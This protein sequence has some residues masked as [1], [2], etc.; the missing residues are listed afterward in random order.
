ML[1]FPNIP[2]PPFK[3][4]Y[5]NTA[6]IL[7]T[8]LQAWTGA[9]HDNLRLYNARMHAYKNG[10]L[11][12]KDM[13][14]Y[15]ADAYATA[16]GIEHKS[17]IDASA[18]LP[19]TETETEV[20]PELEI[21]AQLEDEDAEGEAEA[22][23]E[24]RQITPSPTPKP[25]TP[26]AKRKTKASKNTPVVSTPDEGDEEVEPKSVE[27]G[28]AVKAEKEKSPEKKRKRSKRDQKADEEEAAAAEV[29]EGEEKMAV[30]T[31]KTAGKPRKRSKKSDA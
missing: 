5:N 23:A 21:Q 8:D 9:Y 18:A 22:D 17:K 20:D 19:T 29:E 27:K 1:V 16:H 10:R 14:E 12:A 25:K 30:E 13:D 11:D 6:N 31:P 2:I 28:S 15:E 4:Q 7:T 24:E 3:P 26:K